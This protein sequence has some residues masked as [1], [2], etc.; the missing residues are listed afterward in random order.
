MDNGFVF[1]SHCRMLQSVEFCLTQ[2]TL[3]SVGLQ[4]NRLF[5]SLI[6]ICFACGGREDVQS[7]LTVRLGFEPRAC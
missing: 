1:D 2:S 5:A 7:E 4:E 6:K 3:E